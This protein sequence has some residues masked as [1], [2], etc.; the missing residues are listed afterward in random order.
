MNEPRVVMG[1]IRRG[2]SDRPKTKRRKVCDHESNLQQKTQEVIS[3]VCVNEKGGGT[4][5]YD[6]CAGCYF[7]CGK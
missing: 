2:D 7:V 5:R 4:A 3:A 6:D 1:C